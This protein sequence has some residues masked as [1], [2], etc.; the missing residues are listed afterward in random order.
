[1][2]YRYHLTKEKLSSLT[3]RKWYQ[4]Q[5]LI[6]MTT[7]QLRE[8]CKKEK[9]IQGVVNPLDKEDLI[10]VIL[11]YRGGENPFFI[12]KVREGGW[13]RL[14]KQLEACSL[15]IILEHKM[16]CHA[17]IVVYEGLAI[18][19]YDSYTLPYED[20]FSGTNALLISGTNQLCGIFHIKK[21]GE[22]RE[23]LYLTKEATIPCYESE[24][25]NY[26][27]FCMDRGTS[28]L[29]YQIYEGSLLK[30]PATLFFYEI[31]LL[32]FTIRSPISLHFPLAIDWG[33][34]NTTAGIYLD[35][36]YLEKLQQ[37]EFVP[38]KE[39]TIHYVKFYDI[40]EGMKESN[41]LPSV[42]GI[43]SIDE[44]IPQYVFGY[45]AIK[46]GNSNYIDE[47]FCVFYE[48]KRWIRDYE[49]EEEIYDKQGKRMFV[50]R[51]EMICAYLNYVIQEIRNQFKCDIQ[52]IHFSSP[53]K[54]RYLFRKLFSTILPQY[55][56]EKEEMLDE[57]ISVLY[58]TISEMIEKQTYQEERQYQALILD[59]GGGTTDFYS[60]Y[61][62][63]RTLPVA[64]QIQMEI[65]YENGDTNFGGNNLT[66][67]ILQAVK[68]ALVHTMN[69]GSFQ[70]IIDFIEKWDIDIFRFVEE[71]GK[72]EFYQ[73]WEKEYQKAEAVLP[74][75]FLDYETSNR[76][77]YYRVKN[78]FYFLFQVA[79]KIKKIFYEKR[80]KLRVWLSS[81]AMKKK[82]ENEAWIF[83][84]KWKLSIF[85]K[86]GLITLKECPTISF[87]I[88]EIETLL[89]ADIYAIVYAF[90]YP[91]YESREVEQYSFLR[92]TGQS[93]KLDIFKEAFQEFLPGK[94]IQFKKKKKE[95]ELKLVCVEG[96]LR[97]L[98]EKR[99]GF[100]EITV[101][102]EKPIFPYQ[103]TAFT[104]TGQEV[105]LID[106]FQREQKTGMISRNMEEITFTLFLKNR[107]GKV[108]YEFHYFC[109]LEDLQSVSYEKIASIYSSHILQEDTDSIINQEV[110]FFVWNRPFDWGYLVVPVG[111]KEEGLCLGKEQFFSFENENWVKDFFDG[112]K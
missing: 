53:V 104:H 83:I 17:K 62:Q 24:R 31:P 93:C 85:T 52:Q 40:N 97:Y 8:I 30:M 34:S 60:C 14:Q 2:G 74:T 84:D 29:I 81:E 20:L 56:M 10:R 94:T 87:T 3:Q 77:D 109:K 63:I 92:L 89:K 1:M 95:I 112:T 4:R 75:R 64:Y 86:E 106:G 91:L 46:L 88:F 37:K 36:L 70:T 43:V 78:N 61:F 7:Y 58:H 49:K 47:G 48:M 54:Q 108:V 69:L 73:E 103:I 44:E 96:S 16:T 9:L 26:R 67:R 76:G 66:Y 90:M 71:H 42:I 6:E 55:F 50:K 18:G 105:V 45:E 39:N 12:K 107:E 79:E 25:K 19:F 82:E 102:N 68:L 21:W 65:A 38:L 59:C 111:R 23:F 57:G 41:S 98:K 28:E 32:D 22:N 35:H 11:R 27:L 110:K 80:G 99:Y 13:E 51:K 33:T 5:D 15:H 72:E 100:A 101:T